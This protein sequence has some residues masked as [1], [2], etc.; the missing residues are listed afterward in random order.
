M[1][2]KLAMTSKDSN[3]TRLTDMADVISKINEII[4]H[5]NGDINTKPVQQEQTYTLTKTQLLKILTCLDHATYSL[6]D[7]TQAT[8]D[9]L[10]EH[11]EEMS[12]DIADLLEVD[13]YEGTIHPFTLE[14]KK[15]V[16]ND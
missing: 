15:Y 8:I 5:L 13:L 9:V 7:C 10:N 2:E 1:I 16:D 4:D 14:F 6:E 11:R 3:G 12:W